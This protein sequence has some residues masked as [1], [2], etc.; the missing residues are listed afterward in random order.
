MTTVKATVCHFNFRTRQSLLPVVKIYESLNFQ[1]VHL[2][3]NEKTKD[4]IFIF[5][6]N[7]RDAYFFWMS[8]H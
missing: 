2:L 4:S 5:E 7:Q 3:Q 1:Y 6:E 8:L